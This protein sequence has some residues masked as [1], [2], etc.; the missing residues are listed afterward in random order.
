M[1]RLETFVQMVI[2]DNTSQGTDDIRFKAKVHG[3][4][5]I[6]PITQNAHTNK[7]FFLFVDLACGIVSA[8]LSKLTG[9][10]L[11]TGLTHLFFY[12]QLNR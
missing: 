7:I 11:L 8:F 5:G 9:S 10:D 3:E 1:H 2:V 4:I 12:I 6:I